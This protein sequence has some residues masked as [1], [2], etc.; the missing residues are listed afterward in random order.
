MVVPHQ[1]LQLFLG[2]AYLQSQDVC[3]LLLCTVE[4]VYLRKLLIRL[5]PQPLRNV[6][7]VM[8]PF[9]VHLVRG[10]LLLGRVEPD[11]HFL[12]VCLDLFAARFGLLVLEFKLLLALEVLLFELFL[13]AGVKLIVGCQEFEVLLPAGV[14][15]LWSYRIDI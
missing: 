10:E 3:L 4:L 14:G 2:L 11:A 5:H 1:V 9:V 15:H 6:E 8:G 7:V 12:L 13:E